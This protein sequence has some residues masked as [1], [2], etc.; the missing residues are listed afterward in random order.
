MLKGLL[1]VLLA[2]IVLALGVVGWDVWKLRGLRPPPDRTFEGFLRAGR[3][4]QRL[5]MDPV[6]GRLYWIHGPAPT[7]VPYSRP[8]VYAFNP[9]GEL[10]DW[11]PG[12]D[13]FKGMIS[14][15]PV[16]QAG[17]DVTLEQARAWLRARSGE[18]K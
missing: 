3:A 4:P 6:V 8:V 1:K 16:V 5:R 9:K 11:T 2:L 14:G 10:V 12:T 13:D 15:A 7:L 17:P 18:R